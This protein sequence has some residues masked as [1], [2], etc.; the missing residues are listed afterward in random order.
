[1]TR[2]PLASVAIV[3]SGLAPA[4]TSSDRIAAG[5]FDEDSC[6]APAALEPSASMKSPMTA[7]APRP[8]RSFTKDVF[9][10]PWRTTLRA[11]EKRT[12]RRVAEDR[13][14]CPGAWRL[15]RLWLA[16]SHSLKPRYVTVYESPT[17]VR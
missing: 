14:S 5:T 16:R 15:K 4:S 2:V 8:P 3:P 17:N 13:P 10:L 7:D 1:M 6:C 11:L 12:L 9:L